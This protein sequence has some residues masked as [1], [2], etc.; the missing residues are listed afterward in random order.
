MGRVWRFGEVVMSV[1][2]VEFFEWDDPLEIL[3]VVLPLLAVAAGVLLLLWAIRRMRTEKRR[4]E[5]HALA[6]EMGLQPAT[7]EENRQRRRQ[8]YAFAL[9]RPAQATRK[10]IHNRFIGPIGNAY[11]ELFDVH[12]TMNTQAGAD[13]DPQQLPAG[14]LHAN[15]PDMV[16]DSSET[17]VLVTLEG[18]DLPPLML[19]PDTRTKRFLDGR[20]HEQRLD[21]FDDHNTL[22]ATD[23]SR[24]QALFTGE[25]RDY[26]AHNR[27]L[28]MEAR[29]RG[30]L[31]YRESRIL[32]PEQARVLV[33]EALWISKQLQ[34][35]DA[36]RL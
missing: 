12:R 11:V 20:R 26:L 30:V 29:G 15:K 8:L 31:F 24:A 19:S 3:R 1:I 18:M 10:E 4:M 35:A 25:L 6:D 33:E 14:E 36:G 23:L 7:D 27:D 17:A 32:P 34:S 16:V 22:E 9:L 2:A 13:D 5:L 21:E 28:T